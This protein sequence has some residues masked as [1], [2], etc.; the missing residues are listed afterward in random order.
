MKIYKSD[1]NLKITGLKMPE[2]DQTYIKIGTHHVHT[3]AEL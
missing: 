3:I 2:I 1:R